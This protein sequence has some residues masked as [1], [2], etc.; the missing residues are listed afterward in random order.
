MHRSI[1]WMGSRVLVHQAGS[2]MCL[3]ANLST[4][5][6]LSCATGDQLDLELSDPSWKLCVQELPMLGLW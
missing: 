4:K 3:E 6:R 2:I 1:S 5:G